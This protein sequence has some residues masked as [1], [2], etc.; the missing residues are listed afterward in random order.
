MY[1]YDYVRDYQQISSLKMILYLCG[2]IGLLVNGLILI[3]VNESI[4]SFFT[5]VGCVVFLNGFLLL[6]Y[7]LTG[8]SPFMKK[9]QYY[10]KISDEHI[11]LKLGKKS[12]ERKILLDDIAKIVIQND[13]LVIKLN[14]NRKLSYSL[15]KIQNKEKRKELLAA[16]A[17]LKTFHY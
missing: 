15:D 8:K 12:Y 13:K 1:D 11:K 14:T 10:L 2:A 3:I 16:L 17:K 4:N 6:I 9:G 7:G 5:F